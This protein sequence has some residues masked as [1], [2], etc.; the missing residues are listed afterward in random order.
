MRVVLAVLLI[1]VFGAVERVG[2]S[3]CDTWH[4]VSGMEKFGHYLS[5]GWLCFGVGSPLWSED[6]GRR[7]VTECDRTLSQ[8]RSIVLGH[9]QWSISASR[10][11][12]VTGFFATCGGGDESS[13]GN[14]D[15]ETMCSSFLLLYAFIS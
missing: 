4:K 12:Y 15:R 7:H 14:E 9:M 13:Y 10:S 1:A 5:C 2:E 11:S 3:L 8:E 6:N